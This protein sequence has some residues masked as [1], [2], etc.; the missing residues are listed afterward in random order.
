MKL[1][2]CKLCGIRKADGNSG[3]FC[4]DCEDAY[5]RG[6][7]QHRDWDVRIRRADNEAERE[8]VRDG[9]IG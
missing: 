8:R 3:V 4:R 6:A 7:E 2:K 9:R 1:R 5:D